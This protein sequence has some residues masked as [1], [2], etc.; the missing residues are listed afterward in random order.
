M[1]ATR[2]RPV[3]TLYNLYIND[4]PQTAGVFLGLFADD[5]SMYTTDREARYVLRNMQQG[6]NA[7]ETWCERWNIKVNED[8]TQAVYFS[9]RNTAPEAHLSLNGRNNP[10]VNHINISV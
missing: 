5:T 10:F 4:T 8:K 3:P 7:I 9:H 2:F 6:I 1:G